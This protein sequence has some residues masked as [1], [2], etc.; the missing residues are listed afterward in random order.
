MRAIELN[1]VQIPMNQG[2]FQWGRAAAHDKALLPVSERPV[3]D[4]LEHRKISETADEVIERRVVRLTEYQNAAYADRFVQRLTQIKT[5][6]E[7]VG[8]K[9][10]QLTK[11]VAQNLYKL[12][13]I[14]DEYEVA[15]LYSNGDFLKQVSS[16]FESWDSFEFHLAPPLFSKRDDK[17]HLIKKQYG[18]WMM[19]AYG[20]LAKARFLRGGLFDVFGYTAER[21]MERELLTDYEVVLDEIA[22]ELSTKNLKA[23][24]ALAKYPETIRGFGHVKERNVESAMNE[25]IRLRAGFMNVGGLT[26][27]QAAE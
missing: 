7:K 27:L 2:A 17:G 20:W 12:M 8:G 18:P 16:Q 26:E 1:G 5:L 9:Q 24:I 4:V 15:R 3:A 21:K 19:K 25:R 13:A 10:G 6:E 23:A 11:A 14:K 22:G